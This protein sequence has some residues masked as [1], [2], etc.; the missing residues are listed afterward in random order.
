M[1]MAWIAFLCVAVLISMTQGLRLSK[2]SRQRFATSSLVRESTQSDG[3][4]PRTLRDS[5]IKESKAALP[6]LFAIA[7]PFILPA[8][9]SANKEISFLTDPVRL[10]R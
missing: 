2:E 8:V 9:A 10:L 7:A 3:P 1:I 5:V 4:I 6:F